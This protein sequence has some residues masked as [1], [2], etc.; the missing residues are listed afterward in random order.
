MS[1]K[2]DCQDNIVFFGR[3]QVNIVILSRHF[4]IGDGC[5][6]YTFVVT[7]LIYFSLPICLHESK[8]QRHVPWSIV[9]MDRPNF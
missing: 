3:A 2:W 4:Q 5:I 6:A 9:I 1:I 8:G 7:P